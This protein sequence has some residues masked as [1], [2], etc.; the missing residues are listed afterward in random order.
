MNKFKILTVISF[1]SLLGYGQY[2]IKDS[3]LIAEDTIYN[4]NLQFRVQLKRDKGDIRVLFI[5][6]E[7]D[8]ILKKID[9]SPFGNKLLD[10]NNDKYTDILFILPG[11][12]TE[13]Y[14]LFIFDSI[15]KSFQEIEDFDNYPEPLRVKN[16]IYYYSYHSSGCA[17]FNWDSDLFL[18]KGF[19]IEKLANI[20]AIGCQNNTADQGIFVY[21]YESNNIK[22]FETINFLEINKFKDS[23]WGFIKEYWESNYQKFISNH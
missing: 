8:T 11:N 4:K 23:K 17:D 13:I 22:P 12:T 7:N 9:Y 2:S 14:E 6:R 20:H 1:I 16:T 19:E 3:N 18:I 21:K 5:L 15:A 10:F